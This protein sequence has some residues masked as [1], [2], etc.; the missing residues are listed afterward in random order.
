MGKAEC[1]SGGEVRE[2]MS[3]KRGVQGHCFLQ[4]EN[5]DEGVSAELDQGNPQSTSNRDRVVWET[6]EK[7][8]D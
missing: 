8:G 3:T 1:D 4:L 7:R 6:G 2:A 5:K